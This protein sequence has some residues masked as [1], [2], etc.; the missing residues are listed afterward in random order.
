MTKTEFKTLVYPQS[1]NILTCQI[2]EW[3]EETA[4]EENILFTLEDFHPPGGIGPKQFWETKALRENLP[5]IAADLDQFLSIHKAEIAKPWP[6]KSLE[7][8]VQAAADYFADQLHNFLLT[9]KSPI[10]PD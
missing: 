4:D 1:F 6:T 10:L 8:L 3:L 2:I 9:Q 7:A 5:L